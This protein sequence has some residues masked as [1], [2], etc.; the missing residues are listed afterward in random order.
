MEILSGST[1]FLPWQV[2]AD[3]FLQLLDQTLVEVAL[4]MIVG[5]AYVGLY[6]LLCNRSYYLSDMANGQLHPTGGCGGTG[7][8]SFVTARLANELLKRE[9]Q[10]DET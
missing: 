6:W 4:L 10:H 1:D 8:T 3:F 7:K 9:G 2:N 5:A